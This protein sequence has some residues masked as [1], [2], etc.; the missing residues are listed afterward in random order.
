MM[1]SYIGHSKLVF[2][3][4]NNVL[5]IVNKNLGHWSGRTWFSNNSYKNNVYDV[6]GCTTYNYGTS[7]SYL[8]PSSNKRAYTGIQCEQC[9]IITVN[10]TKINNKWLCNICAKSSK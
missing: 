1:G 9:N 8:K 6:G 5:K 10:Q 7:Y 2:L 4:S 3:T